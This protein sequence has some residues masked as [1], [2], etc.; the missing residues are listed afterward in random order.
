[1]GLAD[2]GEAEAGAVDLDVPRAQRRQAE[3][4][5]LRSIDIVADADHRMVEEPH[6]GSDHALARQATPAQVGVDAL[7]QLRQPTG[8]IRK[9][10]ELGVVATRGPGGMVAILL[11]APLVAPRRLDVA[12]GIK[13]DPDVGPGRRDR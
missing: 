8:E 9:A 12:G 1:A 2:E 10:P 4:L 13:T 11:A 7:A 3:A 6:H 5:V